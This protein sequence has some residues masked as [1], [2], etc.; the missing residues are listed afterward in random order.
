MNLADA[1]RV[2]ERMLDPVPVAR[3][4]DEIAGR[5][6]MKFEGSANRNARAILGENPEAAILSAYA[7]VSGKISC[8]AARALG[9]VPEIRRRES[10]QSFKEQILEFHKNRYTVRVPEVRSV[11]PDLDRFVRALELIFQT[12][13]EAVAFWS[14]SEGAAPVHHDN[15]DIFVVQV[16]GKKKWFISTEPS[17]M[18][19]RWQVIPEGV[20]RLDHYQEV[21]VNVGDVLY[22]PRGTTHRVEG[23]AESIHIS[24]GFTPVTLRE[25]VVACIDRLS[26]L[27]QPLREIVDANI[28]SKAPRGEFGTLGDRVRE[29]VA[30]LLEYCKS[31]AFISEAMHRRSSKIIGDLK[32]IRATGEAPELTLDTR[33]RHSPLAVS[34]ISGNERLID[35]AYPGAHRYIHRGA[36]SSVAFMAQTS[37]FAVRDVPGGLDDNVRLALIREFVANGF[38]EKVPETGHS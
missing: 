19:N 14:D 12:E 20:P 3:F 23:L 6:F 9:P 24:I 1:H 11:T 27:S 13:A 30:M 31:D 15:Y 37:E 21:E 26:D 5:R 29:N 38:L 25:A 10:P 33:V 4:L 16:L 22:I 34:H 35:F 18:P 17:S 7:E 36:E 2:L 32:A 28:A 8:H